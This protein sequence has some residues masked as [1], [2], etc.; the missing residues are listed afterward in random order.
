MYP[1]IYHIVEGSDIFHFTPTGRERRDQQ[2]L[3]TYFLNWEQETAKRAEFL[4]MDDVINL[5]DANWEMVWEMSEESPVLLN[6]YA[7]WCKHCK[8]IA[9]GFAEAAQIAENLVTRPWTL[10]KLD[11]NVNKEASRALA[12]S[13]FPTFIIF[14]M[15]KAYRYT[16]GH[17]HTPGEIMSYLRVWRPN[18]PNEIDLRVEEF[19]DINPEDVLELDD[20]TFPLAVEEYKRIVV[21]FY[22]PWCGHC[23]SLHPIFDKAASYLAV[24]DVPVQMVRVDATVNP[25]LV[26]KYN[27]SSYPFV[28]MI[29]DGVS[30]IFRAKRSANGIANYIRYFEATPSEIIETRENPVKKLGG[31]ASN[32]REGNKP[33]KVEAQAD[34]TEPKVEIL[35]EPEIEIP[36]E[37][38]EL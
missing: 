11:A 27:I 12:V 6:V 35:N 28:A 4:F 13:Q 8:E 20:T 14:Y 23:K 25:E 7:P 18:A 10:A 16:G 24:K 34:F 19:N 30:Y 32:R 3:S 21:F 29:E 38:D 36:T 31:R 26:W 5:H 17:T 1:F 9:K 15:Q 22:A 37:K 2:F 33:S